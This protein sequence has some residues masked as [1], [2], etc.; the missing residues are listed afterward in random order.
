MNIASNP[1]SSMQTGFEDPRQCAGFS[2]QFYPIA[3]GAEAPPVDAR[4]QNDRIVL[5]FLAAYYRLNCQYARLLEVR[6]QPASPE[7]TDAE[8][9]CLQEVEKVL[10]IRDALEDRY[11]PLGV[12]TEPVVREGFT[13]D[14]KVQFGN[15]D[16]AGRRRCDLYTLTTVIPVPMPQGI[17][18]E[19]LP[20]KIEGPGFN[21]EY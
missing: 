20:L 15:M 8:R 18:L 4:A 6:K 5:E 12:I 14:L 16:G 9:K 3:N 10:I 7:R 17:K 21:G 19:D 13:V 2:P 1:N 11:A